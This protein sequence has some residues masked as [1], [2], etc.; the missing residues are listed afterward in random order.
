[1]VVTPFQRLSTLVAPYSSIGF[2]NNTT[3]LLVRPLL[4]GSGEPLRG[5]QRGL[6][7]PVEKP[8]FIQNAYEALVFPA[9]VCV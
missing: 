5:L 6:R 9:A 3:E 8:W 1:M 2:C 4:V 7:A